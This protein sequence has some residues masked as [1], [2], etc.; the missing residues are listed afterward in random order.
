VSADVGVHDADDGRSYETGRVNLANL[1]LTL[2]RME[3]KFDALGRDIHYMR[4]AQIARATDNERRFN[5]QEMRLRV[6]E[7]KRYLEPRSFTAVAG[8]VLPLC[9]IAVAIIAI[10]VK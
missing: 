9:A 1:Q 6:I 2:V 4:E 3:A 5:D 7:S 8:V 10:I